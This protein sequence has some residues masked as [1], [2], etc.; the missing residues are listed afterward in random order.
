MTKQELFE[1]FISM[2]N[3]DPNG[4]QKREKTFKKNYPDLYEEFSEFYFF[5]DLKNCSFAQ[6]LFHFLQDDHGILG[7]CKELEY[8]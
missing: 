4:S 8:R 5:N 6:K 1:Y 7:L 3:P 2:P